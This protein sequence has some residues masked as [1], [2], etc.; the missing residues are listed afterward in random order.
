[1]IAPPGCQERIICTLTNADTRRQTAQ[2]CIQQ[3]DFDICLEWMAE[4]R[5]G[6]SKKGGGG[7]EEGQKRKR[8]GFDDVTTS[9]PFVARGSHQN[10]ST[11][12]T[13]VVEGEEVRRSDEEGK[14][15]TRNARQMLQ[16]KPRK[17]KN[18]RL[19]RPQTM[20]S[21]HWVRDLLQEDYQAGHLAIVFVPGP[22][23]PVLAP[24]HELGQP[25]RLVRAPWPW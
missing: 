18:K 8:P 17:N 3:V 22:G 5:W 11:K 10:M 1:M 15:D 20:R 9:N 16:R 12:S 7:C 23:L 2:V 13:R 21:P 6:R 19:F 24:A 25:L 14:S 4:K